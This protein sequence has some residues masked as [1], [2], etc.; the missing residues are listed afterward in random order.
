MSTLTETRQAYAEIDEFIDLLD[1][2][3]RNKIPSKLR[4]FFKQEKDISYNK[5]I[6]PDIPINQQN[7]KEETLALIA[8]LNLKYICE[9]ENEKATLKKIYQENEE[10]YQEKL[11]ETYNPDNIFKKHIIE[12]SADNNTQMNQEQNVAMIEYKEP[13]IRRLI[14][15]IKN[16]FLR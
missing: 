6:N 3:D 10:K 5:E 2:E 4:E 1:E 13:L 12:D 15:K 16:I 11:R 14:N 9:D 7:L 8:I